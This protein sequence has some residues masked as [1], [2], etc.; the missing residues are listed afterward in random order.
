MDRRPLSVLF[1]VPSLVVGG[2]ERH[3]VTL[4][5]RMD[6]LRF[7]PSVICIG[8]EGELYSEL[9]SA[10]IEARAL[11]LGAKREVSRALRELAAIMRKAQPDVVVVRGFN[12][13]I[14]GRLAGRL[15]GVE[16]SIV[17]VHHLG[18]VETRG[19]LHSTVSR[20]LNR[21]TSS[22]FGVAKAQ[23][24]YIVDGLGCP[25]DRVHIIHNGVDPALFEPRSDPDTLAEFGFALGDPVVGI[26]A[27]LRP[28]KDHFTLLHA[29]RNVVAQIPNVKFLVVGDGP[30]RADLE[31]LCVD[32]GIAKNVHFAGTRHDVGRLMPAMNVFTLCSVSECFPISIL[33]AMASGLPAVCSDVGGVREI[34][35]HG[36][37]GYLVPARDPVQLADRLTELL[38]NPDV[39]K[40][41]GLAGRRRIEGQFTLE[42]SVAEAERA[43]ERVVCGTHANRH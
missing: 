6:R 22:Y 30:T 5:P 7:T 20:A 39:A 25:P 11:H 2:A 1:V 24:P 31:K 17:W 14:L 23:I 15:A 18:D 32:L 19:A 8:E 12:A 43:I 4:L 38:R 41:F 21:W 29:A 36:E 3:L 10:G 34:L 28:E 9:L 13:E 26:V 27:A 16:H 40:R 42:R 33:E 35:E 37:T